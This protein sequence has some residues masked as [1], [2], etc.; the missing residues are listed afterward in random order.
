MADA[1]GAREEPE[2]AEE[3]EPPGWLGSEEHER[4]RTANAEAIQE[5]IRQVEEETRRGAEGAVVSSYRFATER[6]LNLMGAADA[7]AVK[8]AHAK[9]QLALL[10]RVQVLAESAD[11]EGL[12]RLAEAYLTLPS[13]AEDFGD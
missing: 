8:S 9:A 12:T 5:G 4:W 1:D 3:E 13:P 2:P 11:V 7:V 6:L 10:R